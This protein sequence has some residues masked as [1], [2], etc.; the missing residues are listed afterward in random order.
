MSEPAGEVSEA[1]TVHLLQCAMYVLCGWS[2]GQQL[3]PLRSAPS[4]PLCSAPLTPSLVPTRYVL[5]YVLLSP[6]LHKIITL[7][8][9]RKKA[10]NQGMVPY[11]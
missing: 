8:M 7:Y 6:Y 4:P 9:Y 5:T 11:N 2:H 10:C 1:F 3:P